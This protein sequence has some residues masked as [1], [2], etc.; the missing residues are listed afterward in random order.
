VV[1][2]TADLVKVAVENL[3][4]PA[5][6]VGSV[7]LADFGAADG[8]P[9]MPLMHQVKAWLPKECDLEVA[10]EDQPNNDFQSLFALANGLVPLPVRASHWLS[11]SLIASHWLSLSLIVSLDGRRS[12][13]PT[14]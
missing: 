10:F 14:G 4:L 5:D 7:R 1:Q 12:K 9:E 11:L 8:G 6:H 13:A 3:Q 2:N